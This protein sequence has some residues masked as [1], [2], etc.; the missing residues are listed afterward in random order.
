MAAHL[1]SVPQDGGEIVV[2]FPG[3]ARMVLPVV[4][5]H[6]TTDDDQVAAEVLRVVPGAHPVD[7]PAERNTPDAAAKS[8]KTGKAAPAADQQ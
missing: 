2:T 4:D 7:P 1:I 5:G 8:A 3:V 6:V